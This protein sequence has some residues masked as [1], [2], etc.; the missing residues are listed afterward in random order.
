MTLID[1]PTEQAPFRRRAETMDARA[2]SPR[3]VLVVVHRPES[4]PGAVGQWLRA[5]GYRLDIRCPRYGCPLPETLEHHAGAVIFGGPMSVNDSDEY[6]KTEIDWLA[7]PLSEGKPYLGICL[8]AQMLAKHL[9]AKVG[10]HPEGAV[11][12]GYYPIEV[13]DAARALLAWPDRVYQWHCE[14]FTLPAGA[15][16]LAKGELFEN[17]AIRYGRAAFGVQFHPE[18]TLAMINRWTTTAAHRFAQPGARPRAE[19]IQG[20]DAYGVALRKWL[21]DFMRVWLSSGTADMPCRAARM[22]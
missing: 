19:H 11:E 13:S 15:E 22:A 18:M 10:F 5:N 9:G 2:A 8:G 17:Q 7:V 21:S 4:N 20:H 1:F 12:V 14:G 6:L 16:C 3:D